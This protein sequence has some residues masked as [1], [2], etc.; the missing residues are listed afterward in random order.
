MRMVHQVLSPCVQHGQEADLRA[1]VLWVSGDS[2]KC[3]RRRPEQDV[4]NH[5]LVLE[6]DDLDLRRYR[7]HDVEVGHVEQ[8]RLTILQPPGSC[9]T[10]AFWTVPVPARVVGYT[11]GES[12]ARKCWRRER[13]R[14][15]T[16]SGAK[17]F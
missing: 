6:G 10:L 2:A 15:P 3:F 7:E 8:F 4:L 17:M 9:E 11:L 13:N 16:L 12:N 1:Q 5:G 14:D